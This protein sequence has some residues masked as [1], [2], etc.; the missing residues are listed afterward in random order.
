MGRL[1]D[2][3]LYYQHSMKCEQTLICPEVLYKVNS[4][5]FFMGDADRMV[6]TVS[7]KQ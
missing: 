4:R 1:K 3:N 6:L 7:R 2:L 5:C